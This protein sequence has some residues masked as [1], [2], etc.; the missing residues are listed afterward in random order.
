MNIF[1]HL[2]AAAPRIWPILTWACRRWRQIVSA[3]RLG[4]NLRL[5]CTH[6]TP[7]LKSLDCWPALP[8]IVEYGAVPNLDPPAPGYDENIIAALKQSGRVRSINLTVTSSLLEKLSSISE[9]LSELEELVLL[10]QDNVQQIFPST[11]RWGPHLRTLHSTRIA[12][13]SLLPLLLPCQ[14]LVDL[15]LHEFPSATYLSPEEFANALSGTPQ[16]RSLTL[17]LL[18]FPRRRSYLGSP[19]PPG[20]RIVLAALTHLKDQG[21][22]KYLDV[23]VARIEAPRLRDI[24]I[25][26]FSQPTMDALQLGQ[27]IQRTEIHALL[28]GSLA[29]VEIS[30]HAISISFTKCRPSNFLS[31]RLSQ[32]L[33]PLLRLQISCKQLNWQLSC[34]AQICDQISPFLFHVRYLRIKT[35]QPPGEQVDVD[36]EQWVDLLRSFKFSA[37]ESFWMDGELTA[38]ILCAL[39][40]ANEGN[41]AILPSLRHVR[42]QKPIAMGGP[43][44]GSVQSFITSRSIS[45]RLVQV[46]APFYQCRICHHSSEKQHELK[47]HLR[48]EHRYQIL[49][50]YCGEFECTPRVSGLWYLFQKHLKSR[51]YQIV[52]N[53]AL[54][55]TPSLTVSQVNSLIDQHTS[56]HAPDVDPHSPTE[57][58]P[59]SLDSFIL[60]FPQLARC[61]GERYRNM[62]QLGS[63]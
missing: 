21:T 10:S 63:R 35:A 58:Q 37:G 60:G 46:D 50:S 62:V 48:D 47:R 61:K 28:T 51:H 9:P 29:D 22:S 6:R 19:P 17:H 20:E 33:S 55:S 45:G 36:G 7:V 59:E 23:F 44:W 52:H 43:S 18:S 12:F 39:G 30:A 2:L 38:D 24:E 16:L 34:M 1:R 25:T 13:P 32:N 26:L 31:E 3:S 57:L 14:D 5:F 11:F 54:I 41:T 8:L 42:V 15:Q 4:L 40:P 56:L 27:F 53:D 49:C